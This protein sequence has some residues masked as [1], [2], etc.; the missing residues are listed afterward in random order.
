MVVGYLLIH[1][2]KAHMFAFHAHI[3]A[4]LVIDQRSY[5]HKILKL[6][7]F[8]NFLIGIETS[9]DKLHFIS[10]TQIQKLSFL[11]LKFTSIGSRMKWP[12]YTIRMILGFSI[13]FFKKVNNT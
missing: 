3:L 10:L 12:K 9:L 2:L 5:Y 13:F 1:M 8:S 7:K 6:R 4:S 11:W